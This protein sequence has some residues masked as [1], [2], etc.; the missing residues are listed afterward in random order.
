MVYAS[1]IWKTLLMSE[2]PLISYIGQLR[3]EARKESEGLYS[4]G[5]ANSSLVP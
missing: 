1:S 4:V 3:A 2:T 5:Q